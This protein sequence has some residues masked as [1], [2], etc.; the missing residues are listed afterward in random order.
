VAVVEVQSSGERVELVPSISAGWMP[1][2]WMV[3]GCVEALTNVIVRFA[4]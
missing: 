1:W 4:A 2:K 3:C